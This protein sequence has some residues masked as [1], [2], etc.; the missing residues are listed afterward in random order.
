MIYAVRRNINSVKELERI[1]RK[2][3][4]TE[5]VRFSSIRPSSAN[6]NLLSEDFVSD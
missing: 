1:E 6:N 3:A 2:E 4:E 5:A